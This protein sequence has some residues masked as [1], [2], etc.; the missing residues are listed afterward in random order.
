M[1]FAVGGAGLFLAIASFA[2]MTIVIGS[3]NGVGMVGMAVPVLILVLGLGPADL[4]Y[5]FLPSFWQH[6]VYPWNPLQFLANGARAL[7][8]QGAGWWNAATLGLII[9][10]AV[11]CAL[12]VAS[13]L[14]PH[15]EKSPRVH[16]RQRAQDERGAEPAQ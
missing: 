13:V 4:P 16:A 8:F 2:L 6:W 9:T 15:A 7:L 11:G 5:E 12:V 1:T 14:T 10:A 3:I